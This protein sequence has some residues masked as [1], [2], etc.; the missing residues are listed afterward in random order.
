MIILD[1]CFY[2]NYTNSKWMKATGNA[3]TKRYLYVKSKAGNMSISSFLLIG[4]ILLNCSTYIPYTDH[5][6]FVHFAVEPEVGK[7]LLQFNRQCIAPF[8]H[9]YDIQKLPPEMTLQ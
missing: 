8:M 9:L 3:L 5:V 2:F 6:S 4:K 1:V 7:R